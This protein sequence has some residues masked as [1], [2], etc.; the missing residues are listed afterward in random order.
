MYTTLP[1]TLAA[2]VVD[3]VVVVDT[4]ELAGA[5]DAVG[6]GAGVVMACPAIGGLSGSVAVCGSAPPPDIPAPPHA[7]KIDEASANGTARKAA[8]KKRL[9]VL[10]IKTFL[11]WK[12]RTCCTNRGASMPGALPKTQCARMI[13]K[14]SCASLRPAAVM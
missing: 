12:P 7:A 10:S 8:R 9:F 4:L 14:G 11:Y 13:T 2:V 3:C 5:T 6:E 1:L